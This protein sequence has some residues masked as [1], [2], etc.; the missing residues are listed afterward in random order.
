[1]AYLGGKAK[2]SEHI[3]EVLNHEDFDGM[4]YVE[5][6]VGYA[7]ILR[8]VQNKRSYSAMDANPLVVLL[9]QAIQNN[10]RLPRISAK[11]YAE[12]K[13]SKEISLPTATAAFTY[14]YCG[15]EWGGYVDK[16]YRGDKWHSYSQERRRY[17]ATLF[18]NEHF[19]RTK[20]ACQDYRKLT[21]RNKL[22]YCDPP[23][24]ETTGYST[25]FNHDEFWAYMRL[26]SQTNVVF[27]SEYQS[28]PDFVCVASASKTSS[29]SAERT[30]R[31]EKLF[32]HKPLLHKLQRRA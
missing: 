10:V 22:I 18:A 28:P 19:K 7:H 11:R 17:Y 1:M 24:R 32:I 20:L 9:L 31:V 2:N 5:P 12:L 21:C 23:Y 25:S 30:R 26:W 15:K 27:I 29:V 16:Y 4:D 6:F 3:L 8:R 14:S 13:A